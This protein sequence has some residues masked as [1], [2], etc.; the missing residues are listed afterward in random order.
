[1]WLAVTMTPALAS[2]CRTPKAS[3][4]VGSARGRRVVRTPAPAMTTAVSRA[5]TSEFVRPS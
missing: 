2:K 5:K 3:M 4:G 1:L